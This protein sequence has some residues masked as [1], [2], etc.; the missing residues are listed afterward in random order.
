MPHQEEALNFTKEVLVPFL[1]N[2]VIQGQWAATLQKKHAL[3]MTEIIIERIDGSKETAY[4][5]IVSSIT[6]PI[7]ISATLFCRRLLEFLGLGI[8]RSKP[9]KLRAI[10]TKKRKSSDVGIEH[11]TDST[12]ILLKPLTPESAASFFLSSHEHEELKQAWAT[13]Y[14]IANQRLAHSTDDGI[15]KGIDVNKSIEIAYKTIPQLVCMA[16]YDKIGEERPVNI[17][18]PR[19]S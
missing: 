12:G 11:F 6:Q 7:C 19:S 13:V 16:F 10:E 8:E 4:R 5:G 9:P 1:V 2:S 14:A 17:L 15:L 3:D 18:H